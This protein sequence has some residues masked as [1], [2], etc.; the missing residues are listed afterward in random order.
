MNS[1]SCHGICIVGDGDLVHGSRAWG[2]QRQ[3]SLRLCIGAGWGERAEVVRKETKVKKPAVLVKALLL[4]WGNEEQI[5]IWPLVGHCSL[6]LFAFIPSMVETLWPLELWINELERAGAAGTWF[7][8]SFCSMR[9]RGRW[10]GDQD[11]WKSP[12]SRSPSPRR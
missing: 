4:A 9:C 5:R 6:G 2:S 1:S 8:R 12:S 10:V 11:C 7:Y 3:K